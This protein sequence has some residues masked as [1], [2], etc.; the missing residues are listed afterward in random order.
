MDDHITAFKE[1]TKNLIEHSLK[2]ENLSN[3]SFTNPEIFGLDSSA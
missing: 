1:K 3:P 2:M